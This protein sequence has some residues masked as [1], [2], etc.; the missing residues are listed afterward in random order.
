MNDRDQKAEQLPWN[1]LM[2]LKISMTHEN[3]LTKSL[4]CNKYV[5]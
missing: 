4:S 2:T 3:V 1:V 5:Y